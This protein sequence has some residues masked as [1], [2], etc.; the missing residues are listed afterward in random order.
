MCVT[1]KTSIKTYLVYREKS[2]AQSSSEPIRTLVKDKDKYSTT[3]VVVLDK[4]NSPPK[5]SICI[6]QY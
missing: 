3:S 1:Y 2:V 5:P 6:R 4:T